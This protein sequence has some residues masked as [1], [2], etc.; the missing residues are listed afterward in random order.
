VSTIGTAISGV[1]TDDLPVLRTVT[2]PAGALV[3]QA[4]RE[5]S[6]VGT[7][8]GKSIISPVVGAA[9]SVVSATGTIVQAAGGAVNGPAG[10]GS[11][12]TQSPVSNVVSSPA[13]GAVNGPA[14]SGLSGVL[15]PVVTP[16]TGLLSGIAR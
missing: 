11:S 7:E 2:G 13:G 14:G 5:V 9:G 6:G 16:L 3:Y 12:G 4:G 15:A 10:S 8:L 1:G